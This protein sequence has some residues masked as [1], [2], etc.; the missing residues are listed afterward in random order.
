MDPAGVVASVWR[1]Y[2]SRDEIRYEIN[3]D[4]PLIR[5]LLEREDGG[6]RQRVE[7]ALRVIEREFPAQRFVSD[8]RESMHRIKQGEANP[9]AF[10]EFLDISIPSLLAD[11]G[12]SVPAMVEHLRRTEPYRTH[13]KTV[14]EYLESEG[15]KDAED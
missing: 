13:W 8:G 7:G 14:E 4:H 9:V 11:H 6:V 3:R 5:P 2:A 1:R 15:W 10:R 12:G